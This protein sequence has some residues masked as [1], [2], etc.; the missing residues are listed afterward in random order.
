MR[1]D[2]ARRQYGHEYRPGWK[3]YQVVWERD[4]ERLATYALHAANDA[5][6]RAEASLAEHPEHDFDRTGTT[7]RVRVITFPL[8]LDDAY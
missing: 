1:H 6:S 4:G 2:S 3:M 7:V 5:L 8:S